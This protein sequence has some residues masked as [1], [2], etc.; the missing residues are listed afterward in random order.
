[1]VVG[2]KATSWVGEYGSHN[3]DG[4]GTQL[5]V[6][7]RPGLRRA[8]S[9]CYAVNNPPFYGTGGTRRRRYGIK[10]QTP[11]RCS[12]QRQAR[13]GWTAIG[14]EWIVPNRSAVRVALHEV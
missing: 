9:P 11:T 10:D 7:R 6:S 3:D 12:L 14:L 2:L 1:L 4:L 5:Q 8:G 13:N